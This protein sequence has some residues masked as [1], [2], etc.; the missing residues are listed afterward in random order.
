MIVPRRSSVIASEIVSS[1]RSSW[2]SARTAAAYASS[3][4]ARPP[5]LANA[6]RADSK[7]PDAAAEDTHAMRSMNQRRETSSSCGL[8]SEDPPLARPFRFAIYV[9]PPSRP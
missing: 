7:V 5:V 1:V 9:T 4:T 8:G 2:A 6:G 3:A